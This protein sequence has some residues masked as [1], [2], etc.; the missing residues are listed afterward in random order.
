MESAP[1][2]DSVPPGADSSRQAD[3]FAR[4]QRYAPLKR[5]VILSELLGPPKALK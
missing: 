4:L 5:A 2:S 1:L 3:F